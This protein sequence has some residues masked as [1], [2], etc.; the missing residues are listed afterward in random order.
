MGNIDYG[1]VESEAL[2]FVNGDSPR[3]AQRVL[4]KLSLYHFFYLVGGGVENVF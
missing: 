2:T 3:K 1:V 4:L